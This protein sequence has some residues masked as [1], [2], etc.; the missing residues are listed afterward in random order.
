MGGLSL[1][2]LIV[3]AMVFGVFVYP[4][5]RILKRAG[6]SGWLALLGIVPFLNIIGLWWFAFADWPNDRGN[7]DA[8]K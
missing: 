3:L 1:P 7:A 8:F 2:H 6:F 4:T 5:S